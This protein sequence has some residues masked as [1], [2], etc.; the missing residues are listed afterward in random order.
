MQAKKEG[1]AVGFLG[2]N[3]TFQEIVMPVL[4]NARDSI[5]SLQ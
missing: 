4:E 5:D 3:N 2:E 1:K